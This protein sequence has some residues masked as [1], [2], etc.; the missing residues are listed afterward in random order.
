MGAAA[1]TKGSNVRS[2]TART[3]W[4]LPMWTRFAHQ[5]PSRVV[6]SGALSISGT[7]ARASSR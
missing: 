1:T 5:L 6:G 3:S 2:L 7:F 4:S